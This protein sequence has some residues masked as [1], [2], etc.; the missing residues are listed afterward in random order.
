MGNDSSSKVISIGTVKI[1]MHDGT[2]RTLSD[3]RYVPDLRKNLISLS[4][5][6]SKGYRINIELSSIKVSRG[7]LVL[8]KGKRIDNLYIL[9]GSTVTGEIERPSSVL[10]SKLTRLEQ[11]QLGH[12]R[13]K[14]MIV[15]F[16][17]DSLLDIDF[18]KLGHCV[19]ENQTRV[20]FD[21]AVH[22]SKARSLPASKHRFDLINY[23]YSSR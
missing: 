16:N 23:L 7:A 11:R 21:L 3:V 6:D 2:I 4:I 17:R 9:E 18:E 12:G 14:C 19:H 15:S 1:R 8:L 22:K 10:E 20:S 13:E 5:L